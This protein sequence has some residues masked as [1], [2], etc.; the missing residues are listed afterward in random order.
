MPSIFQFAAF[1][2]VVGKHQ[3]FR[4]SYTR[5]VLLHSTVLTWGYSKHKLHTKFKDAVFNQ[6]L[7]NDAAAAKCGEI[8]YTRDTH[9]FSC[10]WDFTVGLGKVYSM[11]SIVQATHAHFSACLCEGYTL[12]QNW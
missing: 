6:S 8:T 2:K 3:N 10:A 11:P 4:S 7:G 1:Q 9:S 12:L 5:P